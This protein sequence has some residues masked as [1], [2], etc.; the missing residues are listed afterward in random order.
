MKAGRERPDEEHPDHNPAE[1]RI[2]KFEIT[3]MS[4]ARFIVR[5]AGSN[6]VWPETRG[7]NCTRCASG[8]KPRKRLIFR[9][10]KSAGHRAEPDTFPAVGIS[11]SRKW[12]SAML[13]LIA[14]PRCRRLQIVGLLTAR[15]KRNFSR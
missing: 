11:A 4:S 1:F 6:P 12:E 9:H 3:G 10:P 5:F 13:A 8:Q 2:S 7:A 14:L 15:Q